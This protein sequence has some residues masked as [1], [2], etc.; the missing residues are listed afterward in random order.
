MAKHVFIAIPAYTGQ[1]HMATVRSLMTDIIALIQRGDKFTL[2][3]DCGSALIGDTRGVLVA[4][5]LASDADVMVFLDNDICWEAGALLK[6]IDHPVDCVAGGYRHR[7]DPESYSI[8]WRTDV[9]QLHADP[10]TGLLEVWGVPAGFLKLSRKM[11][12]EMVEQYPDTEF[13]AEQA[14]NKKAWALFDPYRIG[15]HKMG[16]DIAF[17]RRWRDMGGKVWLDPEIKMG[18]IG[19]KTFEG[20]I[21]NWLR[22]R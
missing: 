19:F 3:D 15:K 5:F 2:Y 14:P 9:A 16:E 12:I 21:G 17:C 11:L 8:V 13:Y 6:L 18:H 7:R 20:H 4:Q 10:Q 22:N 1:L